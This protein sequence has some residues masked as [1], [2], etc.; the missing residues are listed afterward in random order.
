MCSG[1]YRRMTGEEETLETWSVKL[2]DTQ[3]VPEI[4]VI[5]IGF[6]QYI[7]DYPHLQVSLLIITESSK[8]KAKLTSNR[9]S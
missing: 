2:Q 4:S 3:P 6:H 7:L 1:H 8:V 5:V 9:V